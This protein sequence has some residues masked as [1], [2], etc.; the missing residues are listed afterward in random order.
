MAVGNFL[1]FSI[2]KVYTQLFEHML[3]LMFSM[4]VIA[5]L[6]VGVQFLVVSEK[7]LARDQGAPAES[8]CTPIANIAKAVQGSPSL[9]YHLLV[10]QCF[11]WVGNT[12]WMS[13]AGQWF[14]NSVY[15]GDQNSPDG[16]PEKLAYDQGMAA[17]SRG[18]QYRSIL[19]LLSTLAIIAILV[20]TR[21]RPRSVYAPCI[22]I[23]AVTSVLAF[24]AVGHLHTF[25]LVCTAVSIM[26]VVGTF[27]IP[28]GL[29]GTLNR[30]AEMEGKQAET[31]LQMA[32]LNCCCC[33]G[34][35]LCTLALAALEERMPLKAALHYVFVLAAVAQGLGAV[36][37]MFLDDN[38]GGDGPAYQTFIN[39]GG[40]VERN[41]KQEA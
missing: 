28:F 35:Q 1:A 37:A 30:R 17:F 2:M 40:D 7:P 8:M 27:T 13:Y 22:L 18:G 5:T 20:K 3:E 33:V 9:L 38:P 12:A 26:P 14:A 16:S 29:V 10:V 21:L 25:A 6:C 31:G 19:Q 34:Q 23:G 41:V 24:A 11:V 36:G 32:L 15:G 4:C 39:T